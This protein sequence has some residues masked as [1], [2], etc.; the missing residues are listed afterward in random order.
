MTET[1]R[2]SKK[3][4]IF[5]MA[6]VTYI[7]TSALFWLIAAALVVFVVIIVSR[8]FLASTHT[9]HFSTRTH[10]FIFHAAITGAIFLFALFAALHVIIHKHTPYNSVNFITF[11]S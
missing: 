3:N 6:H 10:F 4:T 9:P 5:S 11:P 1:K 7:K 2:P 8:F